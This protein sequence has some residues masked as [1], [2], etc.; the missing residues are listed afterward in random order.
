MTETQTKPRLQGLFEWSDGKSI[1]IQARFDKVALHQD[2]LVFISLVAF[3]QD[4]KAIRA[5]LAAGLASPMWLKNVTL[6]KDGESKVPE[7]RVA[8]ARWLPDRRPPARLRFD[9][10]PLHLP[11]A[12]L[13]A[14]RQRRRALAGAEA[15]A[16]HD[17]APSRLAA[18]R[19]QGA[20]AQE[21][22]RPLSHARLHLLHPDRHVRRPGLD[23]RVRAQERLDLNPGGSCV[24]LNRSSRTRSG[25]HRGNPCSHGY[26]GLLKRCAF[27]HESR[28][29]LAADRAAGIGATLY[30]AGANGSVGMARSN[31]NSRKSGRS[32]SAS[33]AD[34]V[35]RA[36]AFR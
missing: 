26:R 19:P 28:G 24:T 11:S 18:L 21:P 22:A 30:R 32:R 23:R 25:K 3:S 9:P 34:S 8:I 35:R 17:S 29:R 1:H 15:R 6:S 4:V 14:Q 2:K 5:A 31:I 20:G 27:K 12:R 10:R 13:P 16:V 36:F 33:S 7:S